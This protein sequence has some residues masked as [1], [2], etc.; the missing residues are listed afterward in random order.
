VVQETTRITA[1]EKVYDAFQSVEENGRLDADAMLNVS[2]KILMDIIQRKENLVQLTDIRLHDTYTFAHCVNVAIL[3]AMLGMLCRYSK[4]DLKL[5]TLGAMLHDLGKIRIPS[6]I[7]NKNGRLADDE[8]KVI[9]SHPAEGAARIKEMERILPSPGILAAVAAQHHE[10]IDG[11]GYPAGLTGDKIH[12]F[13]KIVAIADVY[14]ALTSERPYKKAYSPS[15]THNIMMNVNKGQFDNE[16][17]KLFFNNVAIYPVG[18]IVKTSHGIGIVKSCEFGSTEM[19]EVVV[20][21]T[22]EG[23][24][25]NQPLIYDLKEDGPKAIKGVIS[26]NDLRH[27]VHLLAIDPSIFLME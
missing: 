20:F 3:S 15:V 4:D 13:A 8:F 9:K 27:F 6:T 18:T 16:L 11:C 12:R 25:L 2:D 10:H 19:P 26:D 5:L 22:N 14:D 21:A 23:K 17:L 24:L 7:L 1:I